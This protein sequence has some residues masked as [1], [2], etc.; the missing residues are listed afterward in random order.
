MLSVKRTFIAIKAIINL[1]IAEHRLDIRNPFSSIFMPEAVSKKRVS[2]PVD[3]IREIQKACF[4]ID[5]DIRWL[6]ALISDTGTRLAEAAGLLVDDSHVDEDIPF[7]DVKP[8]QWRS[9]KTKG[10]RR[11]VHLVGASIWAAKR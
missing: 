3:T 9:L 1:A 10:G 8:H 11:R 2:I 6:V 7:A 4:N 5:D